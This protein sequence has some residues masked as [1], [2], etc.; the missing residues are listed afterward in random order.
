VRRCLYDNNRPPLQSPPTVVRQFTTTTHH[1]HL[2]GTPAVTTTIHTW[3]NNCRHHHHPHLEEQLPSP[4]PSTPGGTTAVTTTIHTWR[5]NCRHHHHPHLEELLPS[6]PSLACARCTPTH[7]SDIL[8]TLGVGHGELEQSL[9]DLLLRSLLSLSLLPHRR[10]GVAD[11]SRTPLSLALLSFTLSLTA[12]SSHPRIPTTVTA[13]KESSC[14]SWKKMGT[15][16]GG[17]GGGV[18]WSWLGVE[19]A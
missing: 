15:A 3:G 16:C 13:D 17:G 9:D 10:L 14:S 1:P 8:A 18:W 2:V 5:N 11:L 6:Q 4:P 19:V 7:L 12:L